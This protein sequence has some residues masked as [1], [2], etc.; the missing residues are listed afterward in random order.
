MCRTST[1]LALAFLVGEPVSGRFNFV[2]MLTLFNYMLIGRGGDVVSPTFAV[3]VCKEHILQHNPGLKSADV[4]D[5]LAML[6]LGW[7]ER[8]ARNLWL[9]EQVLR[10]GVVVDIPP[11]PESSVAFLTK[12]S[13]KFEGVSSG[14]AVLMHA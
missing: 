13:S 4:G 5:L 8:E 9:A 1:E 6:E 12:K 2:V 3:E 7:T 11:L 10:F 14:V